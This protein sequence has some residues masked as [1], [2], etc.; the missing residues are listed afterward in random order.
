MTGNQEQVVERLHRL[1]P[2][3]ADEVPIII[4][5]GEAGTGKSLVLRTFAR[6]LTT[7]ALNG[8]PASLTLPMFMP[9][10]Q[11]SQINATL[12]ADI[13][14][15]LV[16]KW[17]AWINALTASSSFTEEWFERRLQREP[18]VIIL[19][20]VDEFIMNNP[21]IMPEDFRQL[22]DLLRRKY[23]G[24]SKVSLVLGIRAEVAIFHL[25]QDVAD[26]VLSI[27]DLDETEAERNFPDAYKTISRLRQNWSAIEKDAARIL[28][29]PL[30]L[31][32]LE[33]AA[34]EP[35]EL[36]AKPTRSRVFA[37]ALK[38]V[39]K[40]SKLNEKPITGFGVSSIRDWSNSLMVVAMVFSAG[41]HGQM[42]RDEIRQSTE[43]M[44]QGWNNHAW[45]AGCEDASPELRRASSILAEEQTLEL[46]FERTVFFPVGTSAWRFKHRLWQ[47]YLFG[48]YFA[49][50][51][52]SINLREIARVAFTAQAFTIGGEILAAEG[53]PGIDRAFAEVA[54]EKM[55]GPYGQF[56]IG[57]L[58]GLI[59]NHLLPVTPEAM[60]LL[61]TEHE[62]M[63]APGKV[64]FI[65]GVGYRIL[66]YDEGDPARETL[67]ESFV[68]ILKTSLNRVSRASEGGEPLKPSGADL[69]VAS[70]SWCYLAE[71]ARRFSE[72]S[73]EPEIPWPGLTLDDSQ[74]SEVLD[75]SLGEKKNSVFIRPTP[76]MFQSVQF[77]Y[78][79]VQQDL[80]EEPAARPIA[81][82]HYL[83]TLVLACKHRL[84]D[85]E[86]C[87]GV[88]NVLQND[89]AVGSLFLRSEA[90]QVTAI[91]QLC[92]RLFS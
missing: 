36:P 30:V 87:K 72:P 41:H 56:V 64:T 45:P 81:L 75:G 83:Y 9:L 26:R 60:E 37:L 48:R 42:T 79:E 67:K 22:I 25:L 66:R 6:G 78:L 55:Q 54:V 47:D 2:W 3:E 7:R 88:R 71:F 38:A 27:N 31:A 49:F 16:V 84:A 90:P 21:R 50:C 5:T 69:V 59:G 82:V 51:I 53:W 29:T 44:M 33:G 19:D 12:Y 32:A 65:G 46:L 23:R 10:Q 39:I 58:G 20:G 17:I 63:P 52:R 13:W 18:T 62:K 89:S 68:P 91:Y 4:V 92:Q 28:R 57:N 77:A 14:R 86:I 80:L 43:R 11:F 61:E 15:S 85:D 1:T 24:E 73:C 35:G 8:H 34:L 76:P 74:E 40:K 70:I